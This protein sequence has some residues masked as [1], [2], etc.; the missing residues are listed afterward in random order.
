[1]KRHQVHFFAVHSDLM[2]LL[3][4]I[5]KKR[6]LQ[7]VK[8]GLFDTPDLNGVT[9]LFDSHLG[10]ASKG[11]SNFEVSYLVAERQESLIPETVPQIAGGIKYSVSQ[12]LNPQTVI[13]QPGG[14]FE[15]CVISGSLGTIS[16]AQTSLLLFQLFSKEIK[17]QFEKLKSFYLGKEAGQLLGKGWRLTTSVKS[18]QVYDLQRD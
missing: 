14:R 18:P 9:S 16:E 6:E 17:R 13:F 1:M 2:A 10:F 7:F 12:K 4:E 11:D 3:G 5:E 8:A 15:Q